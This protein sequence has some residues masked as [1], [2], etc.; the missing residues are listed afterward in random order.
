MDRFEKINPWFHRSANFISGRIPQNR[1]GHDALNSCRIISHRG[2]HD[3]IHVFENTIKAFETASTMGVWGIELDIR[4]TKDMIPV[5]FHDPDLYRI[6][7][8]AI[9][10]ETSTFDAVQSA[11]PMVPTLEAVVEAFGKKIHL[12][13]EIKKEEKERFKE[14]NRILSQI[15]AHLTPGADFHFISLLPHLLIELTAF[16][17]S[18]MIP[19]AEFNV[20]Q[21]LAFAL[22]YKMAGMAGHYYF[23]TDKIVKALKQEGLNAGTGFVDS[24]N[25]LYREIN[26]GVKWLFSNRAGAMKTICN[27]S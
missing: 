22:K 25:C 5:V 15:L 20:K 23:M 11:F 4:W 12:M 19:I 14:K 21:T 10:I 8:R 3:N 17:L 26:R 2:A 9:K 13:M 6:T 1:P 18:A 16:P 27:G 7:G 24:K